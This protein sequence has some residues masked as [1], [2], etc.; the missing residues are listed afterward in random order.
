MDK[1]L[2]IWNFSLPRRELKEK[3]GFLG[4]V[5]VGG[6]KSSPPISIAFRNREAKEEETI[7]FPG[8]ENCFSCFSDLLHLL[9]AWAY[10]SCLSTALVV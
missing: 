8:F 5:L 3:A 4:F 6:E 2:G 9:Q 1:Y 7:S 10:Y